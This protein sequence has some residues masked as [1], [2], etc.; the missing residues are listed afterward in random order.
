MERYTIA[1]TGY[2]P[3]H[4]SKLALLA[5]LHWMGYGK[6]VCNNVVRPL[7]NVFHSR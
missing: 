6:R 3:N 2:Y 5:R 4:N 7:L 1:A